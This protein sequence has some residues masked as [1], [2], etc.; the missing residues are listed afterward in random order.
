MRVRQLR[1]ALTL[2][3]LLAASCAMPA[4]MSPPPQVR[5]NIVSENQL[6][7]L[8]PGTTTR[9]DVTTLLG[10]PTAKATF[11]DNTWLYIGEVT[12][13]LIAGTQSVLEQHVVAL[14]F[15]QQGVLQSVQ[16]KSDKDS[17]PVQVVSRTTPSPGSEASFLQQLLGNVGRFG[18]G[19]TPGGNGIAGRA[20]EVPGNA[21]GGI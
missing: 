1:H 2:L 4:F 16:Q 8:V 6:K 18:T 10:T 12:K 5:G 19:Q 7:E 9:A 20:G 17:L 14:N 15:N 3:P 21:Q 13:P 11:D